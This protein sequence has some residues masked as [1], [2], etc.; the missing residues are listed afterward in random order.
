[1]KVMLG[2]I[3]LD[4]VEESA[5]IG[6]MMLTQQFPVPSAGHVFSARTGFGCSYLGCGMARGEESARWPC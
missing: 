1:M 3:R 2:D 4:R 5:D 6:I